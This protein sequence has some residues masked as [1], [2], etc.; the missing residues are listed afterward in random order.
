[1]LLMEQGQYDMLW[2]SKISE[3]KN[4]LI[5]AEVWSVT[6]FGVYFFPKSL[7]EKCQNF[8]ELHGT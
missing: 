2:F 6:Q 7:C 1:M 8:S 3:K 5:L 4:P